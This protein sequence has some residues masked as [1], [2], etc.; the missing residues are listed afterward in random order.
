MTRPDE[1]WE[2]T[3]Y[4]AWLHIK[5]GREGTRSIRLPYSRQVAIQ[6]LNELIDVWNRSQPKHWEYKRITRE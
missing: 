5:T 6:V 3:L 2:T 4:Y 1:K